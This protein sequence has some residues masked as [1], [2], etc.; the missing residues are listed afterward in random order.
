[1]LEPIRAIAP[2][3]GLES[4]AHER[5]HAVV[6]VSMNDRRIGLTE[7]LSPSGVLFETRLPIAG[8][9]SIQFSLEFENLGGKLMLHCLGEVTRVEVGGGTSRVAVKI[10]DSRLERLP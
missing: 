2:S 1:M 8:G 7:E 10:I 3:T 5:V 9:S 4:R 6:P